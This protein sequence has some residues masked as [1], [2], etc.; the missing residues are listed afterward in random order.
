MVKNIKRFKK[1]CEREKTMPQELEQLLNS[2]GSWRLPVSQRNALQHQTAMGR[3]FSSRCSVLSGLS[4]R[5]K[6]SILE[7]SASNSTTNSCVS[8]PINEGETHAQIPISLLKIIP[9]TFSLPSEYSL[10][11]EE[12]RRSPSSIK[13]IVKPVNGAQGSGIHIARSITSIRKWIQSRWALH[14]IGGNTN[15]SAHLY[16][17]ASLGSGMTIAPQQRDFV[18]Q[19]YIDKPYTLGG[20]KFD[21]RLYALVTSYRPLQLWMYL[22]GFCRFSGTKYSSASDTL[23]N[24]AMHLTN[25]AVQ[26]RSGEQF[27]SRHGQKWRLENLE[28]YLNQSLGAPVWQHVWQQIQVIVAT[29]IY[30]VQSSMI[31]D[32]HCFELY[33]YDILLDQDLRPWLLEVNSSPSLSSTTLEDRCM[34]RALLRDTFEIVSRTLRENTRRGSLNNSGISCATPFA[35]CRRGTRV[36]DFELLINEHVHRQREQRRSSNSNT[37]LRY[38]RD[39]WK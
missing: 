17:G 26:K 25:V 6:R 23:S 33:G 16:C 24:D 4:K 11:T 3:E 8:L 35:L 38:V 32:R 2:L 1:H 7:E 20:K 22:D 18:C 12:Y 29:S 27:N 39:G 9:T 28:L 14:A 13:W 37:S 10:F 5:K 21:L 34:K 15:G 36:G 31:N 30:S 19:K